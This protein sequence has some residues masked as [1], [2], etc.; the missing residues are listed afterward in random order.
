MIRPST[1]TPEWHSVEHRELFEQLTWTAKAEVW[2]RRDW[3][4]L[5]DVTCD[6]GDCQLHLTPLSQSS[7]VHLP[8]GRSWDVHLRADRTCVYVN[9]VPVYQV[10]STCIKTHS[11]SS[12][13]FV[14]SDN[15]CLCVW[16]DV[17]V[18]TSA[19]L[20]SFLVGLVGVELLICF[21]VFPGLFVGCCCCFLRLF[22][23]LF[24]HHHHHHPNPPLLAPALRLVQFL[25]SIIGI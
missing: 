22:Y 4:L 16:S 14:N 15:W 7:T 10:G 6:R 12:V 25:S 24:N 19:F 20:F 13:Q 21:V 2:E 5:H 3:H 11:D 23:Q 18:Q 17:Q 8:G 1:G 9:F